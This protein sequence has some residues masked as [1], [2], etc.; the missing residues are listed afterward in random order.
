VHPLDLAI[1]AAWH[2]L[3]PAIRADR[4]EAAHRAARL[5][6]KTLSRPIRPW[7]VAIRA[8]D[9]RLA[10]H[11]IPIPRH[12]PD[13]ASPHTLLLNTEAIRT[14][15]APISIP[16]PGIQHTHAAAR[17]GVTPSQLALHLK[18]DNIFH[19]K[20][21]APSIFSKR[22]KP[23]PRIYADHTLDPNATCFRPP[24]P[25]WGSAW[26]HHHQRIPPGFT[27]ILKRIPVFRPDPR[28]HRTHCEGRLRGW[29]FICPGP[30][31]LHI[32]PDH[33]TEDIT[34]LANPPVLTIKGAPTHC[35]RAVAKLYMPLPVWT[36]PDAL[37]DP[38][39]GSPSGI[40]NPKSAIPPSPSTSAIPHPLSDIPRLACHHCLRIRFFSN[41]DPSD[42][43]IFIAHITR[44]LLYGCEVPRPSV[45]EA[46]EIQP[47][48]RRRYT[49]HLVRTP[50]RDAVARLVIEGLSTKQIAARLGIK[51]SSVIAHLKALYSLHRV[52]GRAR[53]I[54]KL[55]PDLTPDTVST[56]TRPRTPRRDQIESLL[57][58]GHTYA[59]ITEETGLAIATVYK[60][61]KS[62]FKHHNV[63]TRAQLIAKLKLTRSTDSSTATREGGGGGGSR[64]AR[65]GGGASSTAPIPTLRA[66]G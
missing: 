10:A 38:A 58:R 24:D 44:G 66:T 9:T 43:N 17:L 60:H 11:A 26:Q 4:L 15:V 19:V 45:E 46:P 1:L 33:L 48:R 61:A 7:C 49:P 41:L 42:W 30:R 62:L 21:L 65:T 35:G 5:H 13:D 56:L 55:R 29:R 40:S 18:S 53:F 14:L 59:Q 57:A 23:V 32:L 2:N 52:R 31:P 39:P 37:G 54:A 51:P 63:H 8:S 47:G 36:I 28:G 20:R 25:L 16:W 6:S 22:G 3:A 64:A 50:R 27:A 12:A 34:H